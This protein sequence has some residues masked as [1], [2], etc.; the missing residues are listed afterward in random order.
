[1]TFNND[2]SRGRGIRQERAVATF[3]QAGEAEQLNEAQVISGNEHRSGVI[4]VHGI[5]LSESRVFGPD[6]A[7]LR[8]QDAAPGRPAETFHLVFTDDR[9]PHCRWRGGRQ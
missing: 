8:A 2:Q 1:M 5:D 6:A 3:P 4:G 7:D 9:L